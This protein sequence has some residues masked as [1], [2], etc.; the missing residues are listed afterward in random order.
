[1]PLLLPSLL[2]PHRTGSQC[3]QLTHT[4]PQPGGADTLSSGLCALSRVP[5][6]F[7]LRIASSSLWSVPPSGSSWF[8]CGGEAQGCQNRAP[9]MGFPGGPDGKASTHNAGDLGLIPGSGRSP[10]EG[11]GN[12]SSILAWRIPWTED[13]DWLQSMGSHSWTRLSKGTRAHSISDR[14]NNTI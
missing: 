1:M 6:Q 13:P 4:H 3:G 10:G 5:I 8:T 14:A 12:H 7:R 2:R 9:S 11:N